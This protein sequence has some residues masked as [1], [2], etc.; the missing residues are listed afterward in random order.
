MKAIQIVIDEPLLDQVDRQARRWK[1]SRSASIRRLVSAG[2][3]EHRLAAL[4]EA[5]RRSYERRPLSKEEREGLQEL[6]RAQEVVLDRLG[7]DEDRW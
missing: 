7:R 2:L 6:S 1:L 3:R 5:E 4:A